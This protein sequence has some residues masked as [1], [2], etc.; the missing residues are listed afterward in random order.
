[1]LAWLS[2]WTRCKWFVHGPVNAISTPL[3]L[4]SLKC[5]EIWPFRCRLTQVVLEKRLYN[6]CLSVYFNEC[7]IVTY[8]LIFW[9]QTTTN[10]FPSV[11]GGG[12][13]QNDASK[14]QLLRSVIDSCFLQFDA[15]WLTERSKFVQRVKCGDVNKT[16]TLKNKTKTK[17]PTLKNKTR[18]R[19]WPRNRRRRYKLQRKLSRESDWIFY[20]LF[21][22][23]Y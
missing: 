17:T 1:V 9:R 20:S 8:W 18:P 23:L 7:C 2:V 10:A 3:S 21:T 16:A 13:I 11:D 4:A 6:E 5:R 22:S 12:W 15:L 19:H 14:W